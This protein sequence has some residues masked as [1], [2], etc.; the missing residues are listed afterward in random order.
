MNKKNARS[1]SWQQADTGRQTGSSMRAW[2]REAREG[3]RVETIAKELQGRAQTVR[4]RLHRF[5][6]EGIEGLVL[7]SLKAVTIAEG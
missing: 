4:R 6:S 3:E 7:R 2:W 5:E 1:G